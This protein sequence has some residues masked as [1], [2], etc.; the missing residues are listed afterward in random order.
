MSWYIRLGKMITKTLM[1][2]CSKVVD[3]KIVMMLGNA[4]TQLC[5]ITDRRVGQ[6]G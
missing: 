2:N 5:V 6:N 1:R 3:A 4:T